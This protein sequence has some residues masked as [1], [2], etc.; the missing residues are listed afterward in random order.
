MS[1]ADLWPREGIG[2][3]FSVLSGT[4]VRML[5]PA[6]AESAQFPEAFRAHYKGRIF[7]RVAE[8]EARR[9]AMVQRLRGRL[10]VFLILGAVIAG[11]GGYITAEYVTEEHDATIGLTIVA[12]AFLWWW[13][14]A[15]V[16][17]YRRSIKSEIYPDI[18]RY[19]GPDFTYQVEGPLTAASLAASG[20]V[21]GYDNETREDY[22]S[23]TYNDVGIELTEA[24][25]TEQ[26][27][28][29]KNRRTV[30]VFRGMFLRFAMNKSFDGHT[31]VT[32]DAG[33]IGNWFSGSLSSLERVALEDPV[34]EKQFE[35]LSS[36]QVEARYLLTP[37]F[38]ERLLEL[39]RVFGGRKIR[40]AFYDDRLLFLIESN[41]NRFEGGSVLEPETFVDEIQS[42]LAEMPVL[43]GIIDTLELDS[44]TRL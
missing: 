42:I 14:Y 29:G 16:R 13:T 15:P 4:G 3:L 22:I 11:A 39:S 2:G 17:R 1:F 32:K 35:V 41:H 24:L 5:S 23:G 33:R 25:L 36:D 31:I 38:M 34:F 40:C 21:P 20:I 18:F 26:R 43:F 8:F 9:V 10:W 19:F 12:L 7:P 28:T 27:G 44:Q 6:D 30:E 37:S